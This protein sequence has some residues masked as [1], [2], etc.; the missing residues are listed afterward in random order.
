MDF[1]QYRSPDRFVG[2]TDAPRRAAP[3]R[4]VGRPRADARRRARAPREEILFHAARL[5][6]RQGITATTTREIAA[7]AGLRQPSLFHWFPHKDAIVEALLEVAIAPA[8][9]F[10]E[11]AAARAEPPGVRL[12]RIL[13]FDARELCASPYDLAAVWL[14][15][16]ARTRPFAR[17]WRLRARLIEILEALVAEGVRDGSFAPVEPALT[18]RL[19][20]GMDEAVLTW[21][22]REGRVTPAQVGEAVAE[23]A[24]R[25][26]LRDPRELGAVRRAAASGPTQG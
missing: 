1:R 13:A 11:E 20:F 22:D 19:V 2:M 26:L 18:T 25:A 23:L 17:F 9:E 3:R 7:A 6:A 21:F 14:A 4:P 5:F 15:P 16:E 10:A 24:L 12:F 8:V